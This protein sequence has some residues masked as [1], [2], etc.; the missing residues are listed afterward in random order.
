MDD[1]LVEEAA[2][3][4]EVV[5]AEAATNED[6]RGDG[7]GGGRDGGRG[8]GHRRGDDDGRCIDGEAEVAMVT[9]EAPHD[10]EQSEPLPPAGAAVAPSG[11]RSRVRQRRPQR[12]PRSARARRSGRARVARAATSR[13]RRWRCRATTAAMRRRPWW[14]PMLR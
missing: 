3:T 4:G 11:G 13:R 9:E 6:D 8:D 2:E 7:D 5:V 14:P 12:R 10:A 1:E